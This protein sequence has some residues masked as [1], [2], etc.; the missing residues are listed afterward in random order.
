MPFSDLMKRIADLKQQEVD[1]RYLPKLPGVSEATR[2]VLVEKF[3]S[4]DCKSNLH[5]SRKN[6]LVTSGCPAA[7]A[8]PNTLISSRCVQRIDQTLRA[9]FLFVGGEHSRSKQF[10]SLRWFFKSH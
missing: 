3:V 4:R 6:I 1:I 10:H 5:R 8:D 2:G 9:L 7:K